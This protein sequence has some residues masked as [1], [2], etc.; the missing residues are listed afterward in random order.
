MFSGSS[1][2]IASVD[3]PIIGK[4]AVTVDVGDLLSSNTKSLVNSSIDKIS[5]LNASSDY[6][7]SWQ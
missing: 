5:A 4:V 3:V 2:D 6:S 7:R 1:V